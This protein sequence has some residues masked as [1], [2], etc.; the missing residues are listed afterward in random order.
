MPTNPFL[1]VILKKAM[2]YSMTEFK[3]SMG[4]M[5]IL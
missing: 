4:M 3:Y 5:V 1:F 2:E